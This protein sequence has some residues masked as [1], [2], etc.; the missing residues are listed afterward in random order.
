MDFPNNFY[1]LKELYFSL[2]SLPPDRLKEFDILLSRTIRALLDL[3]SCVV[4][5]LKAVPRQ[6]LDIRFSW[7]S[8]LSFLHKIAPISP[9]DYDESFFETLFTNLSE[10]T[11][12]AKDKENTILQIRALI[13]ICDDYANFSLSLNEVFRSQF[14][15]RAQEALHQASL[16]TE[17]WIANP[18]VEEFLIGLAWFELHINEDKVK[19]AH[20]IDTFEKRGINIYNYA[21]W[22]QNYYSE[23][24]QALLKIV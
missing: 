3:H 23:V 22:M 24:K 6:L 7:L 19:A 1:A 8:D 11:R 21:L 12:Q 9:T 16:L 18:A 17:Q 15:A 20:W 5:Y 14:K 2:F 4:E 10:L 13:L